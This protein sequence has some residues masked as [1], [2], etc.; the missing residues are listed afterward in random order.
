M[1]L[2]KSRDE[3]NR[4]ATVSPGFSHGLEWIWQHLA[5]VRRPHILECG[6]IRQSTLDVI[7]ARGATIYVADLITPALDNASACWSQDEKKPAFLTN[8]FL[9]EL[10]PIPMGSL[11]VVCCWGLLDLLPREALP[12][13]LERFHSFLQP[14]GVLFCFLREP[15]LAAGADARWWF[16]GPALLGSDDRKS[17][18]Y[19][20]PAVTNREMERLFPGGNIKTFLT[21]SGR[22]ECLGLK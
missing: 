3:T 10:P 8:D 19:P 9:A 11:A 4:A 22:R 21:R 7:C 6:G 14:G 20:Y 1:A 13:V 5:N 12:A 17:K 16:E 18:T 2:F 15:S